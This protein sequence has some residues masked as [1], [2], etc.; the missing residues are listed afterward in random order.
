MA[1]R[2]QASIV[3]NPEIARIEKRIG[4]RMGVALVDN[5]GA[6]ITSHRGSERFAM[7]STFKA[8]LA[9]ALFAAHDRGDVD[10]YAEFQLTRDDL[11]PY[12]PIVE[13]ILATGKPTTLIEMAKA[14]VQ[15][16]DNA[17]A[18][19]VLNAIGGPAGFTR[20]VRTQG[21]SI[22]RLDRYE[23]DLNENKSGDPRDT[24][25]PVAMAR[26][27]QQT[28]I[29]NSATNMDKQTLQNWMKDS[30]TGL[31]RIRAGLPK[32]WSAGDKTGTA[33]GGSA[34]NDV[35]IIWPSRAEYSAGPVILTV[36]TDH[37]AKPAKIVNGAIADV[38]RAIVPLVALFG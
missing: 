12:A 38:S 17:A 21:D 5:S 24:S 28:L 31:S 8:P 32:G 18:N 22:T 26:L 23:T 37:P 36:F 25:S 11:V 34:Y 16:S 15:T 35:A 1:G 27:L 6:L 4:G 29:E 19:L 20:F 30:K 2:R 7:C 3:S 14:A 13:K 10:I 33:P 9:S